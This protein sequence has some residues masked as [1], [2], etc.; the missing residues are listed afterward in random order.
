MNLYTLSETII[1]SNLA[2]AD[3]MYSSFHVQEDPY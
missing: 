3:G 1:M 2:I